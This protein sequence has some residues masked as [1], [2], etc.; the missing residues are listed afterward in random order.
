MWQMIILQDIILSLCLISQH[1]FSSFTFQSL[2]SYEEQEKQNKLELLNLSPLPNRETHRSLDKGLMAGPLVEWA[3]T[4]QEQRHQ[5]DPVRRV[6]TAPIYPGLAKPH[7][8]GLHSRHG[9]W[10]TL[11]EVL[12]TIGWNRVLEI[13]F[14]FGS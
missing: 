13:K 11:A 12:F 6:T 10:P 9:R 3:C 7:G 14:C 8:P 4:P 1:F 5:G 2:K